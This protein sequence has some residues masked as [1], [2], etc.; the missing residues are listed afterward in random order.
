MNQN[1]QPRASKGF[2]LIE[3]LVV[4]G[5]IAL[6]LAILLPALNKARATTRRVKDQT[7]VQQIHKGFLTLAIDNNGLFPTPGWKNRFGTVPG[8]GAEDQTKNDHG[9]LYSVCVMENAFDPQILISP[10]ENSPNVISMAN[11]NYASKNVAQDLWW[12]PQLK[13]DLL[14]LSNVS[15]GTHLLGGTRKTKEWKDTKNSRY[16]VLGNRGVQNGDLTDAIYNAS[17]TL[18]IHGNDKS[19]EGGICYNDNHVTYEEGF[20]PLGHQF[21]RVNNANVDDNI[22]KADEGDQGGD[23]FLTLCKGV[24]GAGTTYTYNITW[25]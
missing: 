9:A 18:G 23:A 2:T 21:A 24:T 3:L 5:I 6:L 13:A 7:Q 4:M 12:D 8:R 20:T 15:Y 19:W 17:R 11:Y 14:V 1:K 16:A 10:S 25:D 22:F